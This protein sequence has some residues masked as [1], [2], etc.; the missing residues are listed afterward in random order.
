MSLEAGEPLRGTAVAETD[1]WV[2]LESERAWGP[3]GLEDSGLPEA[4]LSHLSAF[5]KQHRRARVQ[6]IRRPERGEDSCVVY[7]SSS[8][9]ERLSLL[10]RSLAS[11]DELTHVDLAAWAQGALPIGFLPVHEPLYLVCTH[12]KRDKCCAQLGL[13]V[14]QALTE[15]VGEAAWQ[16][17]HLGGHRF[18]ATLLVLPAGVC[19]GRVEASEASELSQAHARNEL[20]ALSRLRGRCAYPGAAQAAEALLREQLGELRLDALSLVSCAEEQDGHRVRFQHVPSELV[21]ELWVVREA[22]PAFPAS[23]GAQAKAGE[24]FIALRLTGR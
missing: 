21:H 5:T 10:R 4:V 12:G 19:Y 7:L 1:L 23:C 14:Y 13:P 16:T 11:L 9:P 3:K 20:Y 2:V 17:T 18:A 6:L 8:A 22:L 15:Q 24:R